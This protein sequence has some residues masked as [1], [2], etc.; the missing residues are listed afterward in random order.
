MSFTIGRLAHHSGVT[1]ETIRYYERIGL[2]PP[3]PRS[4]GGHRHYAKTDIERLTFIRRARALGFSLDEVRDLLALAGRG[5]SCG[6]VQAITMDHVARIRAKIADLEQMAEV[7]TT[8]AAAC[9]GGDVPNCP[10]VEVLGGGRAL[11]M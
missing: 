1:I 6:E 10:I 7:L 2:V 11:E 8:T 4:A 5:K 3:P 9:V